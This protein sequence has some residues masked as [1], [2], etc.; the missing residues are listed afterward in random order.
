VTAS[1]V[2]LRSGARLAA[3][4]SAIDGDFDLLDFYAHDGF[5]WIDGDHGFVATG[6][7]ALVAPADATALLADIGHWAD[8]DTPAGAGPR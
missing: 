1:H 7:A 4:S 2:S 8:P 5:A 6:V 3:R